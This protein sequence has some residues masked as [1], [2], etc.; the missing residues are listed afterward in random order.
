MATSIYFTSNP[1][2]FVVQFLLAEIVGYL[3]SQTK[4]G[5]LMGMKMFHEMSNNFKQLSKRVAMFWENHRS[6]KFNLLMIW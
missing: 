5:E 2:V 3:T 4:E 1:P 6:S